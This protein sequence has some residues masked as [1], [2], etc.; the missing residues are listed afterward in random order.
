MKRKF[1][2]QENINQVVSAGATLPELLSADNKQSFR[3]V[4]SANPEKNHLPVCVVNPRRVLPMDVI[5]SGFAL[6]CFGNEEKA[7]CRYNALKQSFKQIIKTIGD[8]LSEGIITE[9]D[10]MVTIE[11]ESTSH[12]DFYEYEEC[13]PAEIF[14]L[15]YQFV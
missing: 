4:F 7:K 1:K 5:T 6:S 10:G 3:Y 2:Y 11:A 14:K 15:K 8:A 9:Q 12:F 13:K